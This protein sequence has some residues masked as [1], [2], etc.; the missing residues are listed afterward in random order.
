MGKIK[1]EKSSFALS[2]MGEWTTWD[3]NA[4][5]NYYNGFCY[6]KSG[7]IKLHYQPDSKDNGFY[8]TARFIHNNRVHDLVTEQE[9]TQLGWVRIVKKW[10]R[11]IRA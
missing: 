1:I 3:K 10:A 6:T 9:V 11:E 4:Q 2:C 5:Y 8:A 7:I